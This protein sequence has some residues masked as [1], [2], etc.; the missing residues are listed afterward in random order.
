MVNVINQPAGVA[1]TIRR[2]TTAR[3][4]GSP[5]PPQTIRDLNTLT[6]E[7]DRLF[8]RGQMREALRCAEELVRREPGQES[9]LRLGCV[10]VELGRFREGLRSFRRALLHRG[11]SRRRIAQ[12]HMHIA[13]GWY[14]LRKPRRMREALRRADSASPEA[15]ADFNVHVSLGNFFFGRNEFV[16][17]ANE[18]HRALQAAKGWQERGKSLINLGCAHLRMGKLSDAAGE[19]DQAIRILE[20]RGSRGLL[21]LARVCRAGV[22]FDQGHLKQAHGMFVRA[23]RSFARLGKLDQEAMSWLNAGYACVELRRWDSAMEHLDRVFP[24]ADQTGNLHQQA[25]AF[26]CLAI[27]AVDRG[28]PVRAHEEL[29]RA[30][31]LLVGTRNPMAQLYV[32]RARTR[33]AQDSGNWGRVRSEAKR[34]QQIARRIMDF[35]RTAEFQRIQAVAE[36]QLGRHRAARHARLSA[37]RMGQRVRVD[38]GAHREFL[39]R[40]SRLAPTDLPLLIVGEPGAGKTELA[41]AIHRLSRRSA[42]PCKIVECEHL[43]FVSRDLCG[44]VKG[45]WTGAVRGSQGAVRGAGKG[46]VVLDRIDELSPEQQR[47]LIPI[48]DKKMRRV[49]SPHEEHA[50]VR[51]IGTCQDLDG[52]IPDVRVR[53]A[54]AI[55]HMPPLRERRGDIDELIRQ[56]LRNRRKISCEAIAELTERSWSGNL[57]E[58]RA[59]VERLVAFTH[60]T[61]GRNE[62]LRHVPT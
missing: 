31:K 59:T 49:G 12:I 60:R 30:E 29:D 43:Q 21:S 56:F 36:E 1:G 48:L 24:L 45:A 18:Y 37:L 53:I 22:H 32:V 20:K 14:L 27:V 11:G 42:R 15:R 34:G 23:A 5:C 39:E 16:Q 38:P 17:A 50:D 40:V 25:C 9:H 35:V 61:I 6:T 52:V 19:L 7:R 62:V 10:L 3:Q 44:H 13:H 57:T 41:K 26:A 54:G 2:T 51:F 8:R 55:L 4:A 28:D 58:L 47:E 33:I 46:T